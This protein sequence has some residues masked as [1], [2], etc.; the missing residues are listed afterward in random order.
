MHSNS[1]HELRKLTETL[2]SLP[3]MVVYKHDCAIDYHPVGDGKITGYYLFNQPKVSVQR[4]FMSKATEFPNHFHAS[5]EYGIV[6][7]GRM[8][9]LSKGEVKI[10]SAGECMIFQ[11]DQEHSG[12]ALEDCWVVFVA[13]PAAEG[14]PDGK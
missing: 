11:P 6:Y 9:V 3:E 13:I 14:Y 1:L 10:Y 8:E 2:T 7:E 4:V 12:I 5:I